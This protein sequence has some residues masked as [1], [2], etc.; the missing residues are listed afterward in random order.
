[1]AQQESIIK[2]K[3]KIGDLTFYK[4]KT[5]YQVRQATGVSADRIASDPNFQRTRENNAEFGG[6]SPEIT[7][8]EPNRL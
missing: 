2:L 7:I 3:G 8:I 6:E 1:M 4:T 5:G